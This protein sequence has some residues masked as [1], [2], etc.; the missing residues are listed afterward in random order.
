MRFFI[1]DNTDAYFNLAIEQYLLHNFSEDVLFLWRSHNAVV[2]GKHQNACAEANYEF[3]KKNNIK[4]AR[5]LSGGGTVFHDLGNINF[6]L[7]RNLTDGMSKA[8]DY[9]YLLEPIRT[10]LADL[11]IET[12]YSKRDDLLL[13]DLKISGNA[14]HIHQKGLR[15]LHHG[16]LLYDSDLKKLN[17]AIR[18][19]GT[20]EGKSVPSNRSEV[21]NIREHHNYGETE[22]FLALLGKGMKDYFGANDISL[23]SDEITK[24]NEIM[25]ERFIRESWIL[26]YS[27]KYIHHRKFD[28]RGYEYQLKMEVNDAVIEKLDIHASQDIALQLNYKKLIGIELEWEKICLGYEEEDKQWLI[29]LF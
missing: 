18:S 22:A 15:N 24:I 23:Y 28:Y 9:R 29:K 1:S 13:N 6:T 26:G 8:V 19:E 3:C 2:L 4:I 14:Q 25:E 7:I 10:V 11:N 12:T 17:T 27:P 5:R 20:Y 16:T 21:T